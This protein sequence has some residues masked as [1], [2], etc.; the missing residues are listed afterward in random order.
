[1]I[2]NWG[3][4]AI[5]LGSSPRTE[6]SQGRGKTAALDRRPWAALWRGWKRPCKR[7][8][9]ESSSG[10][11]YDEAGRSYW[12]R[13]EAQSRRCDRPRCSVAVAVRSL[14]GQIR[15]GARTGVP[16]YSCCR[17]SA[18]VWG[19]KSGLDIQDRRLC[20][21]CFKL[22]RREQIWRSGSARRGG[23]GWSCQ[24]IADIT[25]SCRSDSY[26]AERLDLQTGGRSRSGHRWWAIS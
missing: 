26:L 24:K 11:P 16:N 9:L 21:A 22:S 20:R 2:G 13:A 7:C 1:M 6:P 10:M 5:V 17:R 12:A 15:I 18:P 19:R 23:Q 14:A 3:R 25:A 8:Y 4:S